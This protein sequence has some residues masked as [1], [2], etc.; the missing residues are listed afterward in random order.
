MIW[1]AATIP[2]LQYNVLLV[3]SLV[4]NFDFVQSLKGRRRA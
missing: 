3:G 4:S 2:A 1:A